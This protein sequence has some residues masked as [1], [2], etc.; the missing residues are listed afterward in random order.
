[1]RKHYLCFSLPVRAPAGAFLCSRRQRKRKRRL[2]PTLRPLLLRS[3]AAELGPAKNRRASNSSGLL[4]PPEQAPLMAGKKPSYLRLLKQP[5]DSLIAM[6]W[7]W[8]EKRGSSQTALKTPAQSAVKRPKLFEG[9]ALTPR[10]FRS[11]AD[12]AM[13]RFCSDGWFPKGQLMAPLV[14]V[15]AATRPIQFF[16]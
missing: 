5:S 7:Q 6:P 10:V 15:R 11:P 3:V 2:P 4:L 13:R 12:G 8:R 9:R 14:G 16:L 1:M